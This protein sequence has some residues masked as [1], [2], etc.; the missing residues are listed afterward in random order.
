MLMNLKK[1]LILDE[2][3]KMTLNTDKGDQ[4][5]IVTIKKPNQINNKE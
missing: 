1:D 5:L 3:F 2:T 4:E